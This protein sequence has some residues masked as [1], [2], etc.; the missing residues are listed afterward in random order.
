[1]E[2]LAKR[3]AQGEADA[4]WELFDTFGPR[5]VNLFKRKGVPDADAEMLALDCLLHVK[6]QIGKYKPQEGGKFES[7][8]FTLAIRKWLDWRNRNVTTIYM[9]IQMLGNLK[10]AG[11]QPIASVDAAQEKQE[12]PEE[13]YREVYDALE[14]L[15]ETDREVIKL[16]YLEP[17]LDNAELAARLGIR[18]NAAKVRLSRALKHLKT[19]LE[20]DPRIKTRK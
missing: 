13:N 15:S 16:R 9:D 14:R 8:V 6:R 20:S 7:W 3:L 1:M 4:F 12:S 2:I 17:C 10:G 5:L 19:I 18:I 11:N